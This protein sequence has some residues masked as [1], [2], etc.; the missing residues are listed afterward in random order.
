LFFTF[1]WKL[2]SIKLLQLGGFQ[3][4]IYFIIVSLLFKP[5]IKSGILIKYLKFFHFYS[6]A[7]DSSK[8]VSKPSRGDE[9]KRGRRTK[10]PTQKAIEADD[11]LIPPTG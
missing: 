9:G 6:P 7:R 11:E 4:Q 5:P 2:F 3:C 8:S 1:N 10:T